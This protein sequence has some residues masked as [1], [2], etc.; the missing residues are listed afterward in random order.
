MKFRQR[1]YDSGI[2]TGSSV[3]F[4]KRQHGNDI[5]AHPSVVLKSVGKILGKS[6]GKKRNN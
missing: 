5:Q 6:N 4:K 2:V 1:T 3:F